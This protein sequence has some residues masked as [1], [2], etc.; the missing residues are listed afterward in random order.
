MFHIKGYSATSL[1]DIADAMGLLKG[2][3]YY[4]IDSKEDLLFGITMA[5][6]ELALQNLENTE[7]LIAPSDER[8]S[9]FVEHH[10]L[11]FANN[12][13]MVRVFYTEYGMLTGERRRQVMDERRR[14]EQFTVSLIEQGQS[15]GC[16]CPNLDARLMATAILTMTNSI[17]IWYRPGSRFEIGH[18][19]AECGRFAVRGLR[20]PVDGSHQGP[21]GHGQQVDH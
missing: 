14:Y 19:A 15:D 5:I 9:Y 11:G 2:S 13:P 7:A 4:Y 21:S 6:H 17:Y 1:K 20:C 8:L 18:V 3:L 12:L 16:F 10:L